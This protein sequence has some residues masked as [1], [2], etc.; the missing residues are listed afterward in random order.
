M[1]VSDRSESRPAVT[2]PAAATAARGA[3]HARGASKLPRTAAS[4]L[5]L[6]S[7]S[8]SSNSSGSAKTQQA[9]GLRGVR[10]GRGR[11]GQSRLAAVFPVAAAAPGKAAAFATDEELISVSQIQPQ[12]TPDK[13]ID[14]AATLQQQ[15]PKEKVERWIDQSNAMGFKIGLT[16]S[17]SMVN[18]SSISDGGEQTT[19]Q[20]TKCTV[21]V[22][23][24]SLMSPPK[25]IPLY[26]KSKFIVAD[27]DSKPV[28]GIVEPEPSVS[29]TSTVV[30]DMNSVSHFSSNVDPLNNILKIAC[31]YENDLSDI[32]LP[33]ISSS[34]SKPVIVASC[35]DIQ[36]QNECSRA[37][38]DDR[39]TETD[40]AGHSFSSNAADNKQSTSSK[41][42][43]LK[44]DKK[45]NFNIVEFSDQLPEDE[46]IVDPAE[47]EIF[48]IRR[49]A[50]GGP[51]QKK[52]KNCSSTKT[53]DCSF[54][55]FTMFERNEFSKQSA[56]VNDTDDFNDNSLI[57]SCEAMPPP[58]APVT[59]NV[60]HC[61]KLPKTV[62]EKVNSDMATL[63]TRANTR[64]ASQ[65][66]KQMLEPLKVKAAS[67]GVKNTKSPGWSHVVGA[68]KDLKARHVGLNITGGECKLEI[69]K[70]GAGE[71]ASA[72]V[73]EETSVHENGRM[74]ESSCESSVEIDDQTQKYDVEHV[75]LAP[76]QLE[77]LE[78][79]KTIVRR[80]SQESKKEQED[81][82]SRDSINA[83]NSPSSNDSI[84]AL[85]N[86]KNGFAGLV[87]EKSP[88]SNKTAKYR[89]CVPETQTPMSS[90]QFNRDTADV[91]VTDIVQTNV[92]IN[93][94]NPQSDALSLVQHTIT[95]SIE[96]PFS[97]TST[98][99]KNDQ[100]LGVIAQDATNIVNY[101]FSSTLNSSKSIVSHEEME[102]NSELAIDEQFINCNSVKPESST[103]KGRNLRMVYRSSESKPT[104]PARFKKNTISNSNKPKVRNNCNSNVL[105]VLT[106][107]Q[108]TRAK[109]HCF[110]NSHKQ[111]A[112]K[113]QPSTP[114]SVSSDRACVGTATVEQN[115]GMACSVITAP[116]TPTAYCAT[117]ATNCSTL[118][119]QTS[120]ILSSDE[121]NIGTMHCGAVNNLNAFAKKDN[122]QSSGIIA[123]ES[124][125]AGSLPMQMKMSL[126][127]SQGI[128][129]EERV[130]IPTCYK[131]KALQ[132]ELLSSYR[133]IGV[134]C[135]MQAK[136]QVN[137]MCI[138]FSSYCIVFC[139][140]YKSI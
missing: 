121:S 41:K 6:Q 133:H 49:P 116:S 83:K 20:L 93:G 130:I 106:N 43:A 60:Q 24:E 127:D 66:K 76:K 126:E 138:L 112:S 88:L 4:T 129:F 19:L 78:K 109:V 32:E 17:Q 137:H 69:T 26:K 90:D 80:L 36:K 9:R 3:Q 139:N 5:E 64:Y 110:I 52:L 120:N 107:Q 33:D 31:D 92:E 18:L 100:T 85:S 8:S 87:S 37:S 15:K 79:L 77:Q 21:A 102:V 1:I 84:I 103:G 68:K 104:T 29:Q 53:D 56:S 73:S 119:S 124:E 114:E 82:N 35:R 48:G 98:G 74:F 13:T 123:K 86:S 45:R 47:S 72:V 132:V 125:S 40:V 62:K 111:L 118:A 70:L 65:L 59:D 50:Y 101:P 71:E 97:L 136:L 140:R 54:L 135:E 99:S 42:E 39:N 108:K 131:N 67:V 81:E 16:Q 134:Q 51:I 89:T 58:A 23:H 105:S 122:P 63:Q 128:D 25:F 57:P 34:E 55:G 113:C 91:I 28:A 30:F 94:G 38:A 95:N 22:S 11:G 96:R 115:T 27:S 10:G 14:N 7:A 61:L 46:K 12:K 117:Q 75:E 44:N 2:I